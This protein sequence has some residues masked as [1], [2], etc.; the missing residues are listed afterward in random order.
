MKEELK[1]ATDCTTDNGTA[2]PG[3]SADKVLT[4]CHVG[5]DICTFGDLIL[6]PHLT[7]ALQA[8]AAAAFIV[9]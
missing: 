3:I 6:I 1:A 8:E 9:S 4:Y 2:I 7:Y 5:D